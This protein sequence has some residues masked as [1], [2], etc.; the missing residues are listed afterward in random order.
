MAGRPATFALETMRGLILDLVDAAVRSGRWE[1]RSLV[2][3][4][5]RS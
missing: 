5:R 3:D 1:A 2:A 4:A